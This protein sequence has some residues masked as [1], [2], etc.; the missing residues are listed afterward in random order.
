MPKSRRRPPTTTTVGP[1]SCLR[2]DRHQDGLIM[3]KELDASRE[4]L[5]AQGG[6][7]GVIVNAIAE[8]LPEN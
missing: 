3:A 2:R 7:D 5:A 4:R 1:S 8:R 6:P